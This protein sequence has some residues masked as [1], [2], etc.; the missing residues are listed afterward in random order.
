MMRASVSLLALALAVGGVKASGFQVPAEAIRD[1]RAAPRAP[2]IDLRAPAAM[3]PQVARLARF[4]ATRLV[5]VMRLVGLEDAGPPIP[6]F[7]VPEDAPLAQQTPGW[8]AGFARG[9]GE[10]VVFPARAPSYP[11]DSIEELL[12]HEVAHVLIGRAAGGRPVP[13]WFHEGVA[14]AAERTWRLADRTQFAIDV[15]FSGTVPASSLDRL[16]AAGPGS[17]DRAY[18]VSGMLVQDLLKAHGADLP[19]RV[20]AAMR[21]GRTFDAAFQACAG[22]SVDEASRAFWHRRRLWVTWLP[23]LTTPSALW[24]I[25]TLL[26][27][28]AI[29][30]ARWRRAARRWDEEEGD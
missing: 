1:S 20:L 14:L 9:S 17:V 27:L 7:L 28:A 12:Q 10:V 26:A 19:A 23:W 22:T 11:H 6:V 15:A 30:R 18:R 2:E 25:V 4:D 5:A 3:A 24:A 21:G 29:A 8:I 13:R 16:F